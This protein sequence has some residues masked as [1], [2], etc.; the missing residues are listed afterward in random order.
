MLP[1]SIRFLVAAALFSASVHALGYEVGQVYEFRGRPGDFNPRFTILH[2]EK[3][4]QLGDIYFLKVDGIQA[5]NG[6]WALTAVRWLP[7][8][9]RALD[10]SQ[11]RLVRAGE[12]IVLEPAYLIV[13]RREVGKRGVSDMVVHKSL[14]AA[15][16]TIERMTK[17]EFARLWPY[18]D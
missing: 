16:T 3:H 15:F 6:S 18:G 11:P 13:W 1:R 2:V 12:K 14:A 7:A 9:R 10:T 17:E 8:T 5:R 4:V